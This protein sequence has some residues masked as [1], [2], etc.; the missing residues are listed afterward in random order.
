MMHYL[1]HK[2]NSTHLLVHSH[3]F[4]SSL[5]QIVV[6]TPR[7]HWRNVVDECNLYYCL[8]DL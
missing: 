2:T 1:L 3:R 4:V 6:Y 7:K 5:G 8:P